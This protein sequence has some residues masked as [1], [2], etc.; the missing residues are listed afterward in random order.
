MYVD[1]ME[2]KDFKNKEETSSTT[3]TILVILL[4]IFILGLGGMFGFYFF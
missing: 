2:K 4:C 3:T 1:P